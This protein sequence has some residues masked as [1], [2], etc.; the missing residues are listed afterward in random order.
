MA[1]QPQA[2]DAEITDEAPQ[3]VAATARAFLRNLFGPI[4]IGQ[5]VAWPIFNDVHLAEVASQPYMGVD[6]RGRNGLVIDLLVERTSLKGEKFT[7]LQTVLK[8][9][10]YEAPD[11]A[12]PTLLTGNVEADVAEHAARKEA[13]REAQQASS[14]LSSN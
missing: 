12:E 5:L 14:V 13:Y 11:G 10:V 2:I 6:D 3:G 8:R 4:Q 1:K 7:N 9:F